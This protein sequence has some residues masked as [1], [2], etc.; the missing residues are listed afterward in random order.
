MNFTA[1]TLV[2]SKCENNKAHRSWE[3][4]FRQHSGLH[5]EEMT[6]ELLGRPAV[7]PCGS[8]RE[9][10]R[11]YFSW[12]VS[13]TSFA[14]MRTQSLQLCTALWGPV[15]CSLPGSSC[16]WHS[17]DKNTGEGCH[18]L[19]QGILPTQYQT[20]VSCL[21]NC[22]CS[23]PSHLWSPSSS[24]TSRTNLHVSISKSISIK[25]ERNL[26]RLKKKRWISMISCR[27]Q[28]EE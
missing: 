27:E 12:S 16:P 6:G 5:S 14:C 26:Q 25:S 3:K 21:L 2:A 15:D 7:K 28:W 18:F 23:L 11:W 13:L 8:K 17:L 22:R 1:V 10:K 20:L 9:R 24:F 4:V 19:L